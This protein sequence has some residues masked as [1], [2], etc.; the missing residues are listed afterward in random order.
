MTE[1]PAVPALDRDCVRLRG[2]RYP[3]T[4]FARGRWLPSQAHG[5]ALLAN[6]PSP[7]VIVAVRLR[8]R[9]HF[10]A[11]TPRR[12]DQ[13][14]RDQAVNRDPGSQPEPMPTWRNADSP[15]TPAD[16]RLSTAME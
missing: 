8:R 1:Q 13:A 15:S 16:A 6:W 10:D 11:M 4:V 14:G 3:L 9:V 12:W 2:G 7:V 5:H